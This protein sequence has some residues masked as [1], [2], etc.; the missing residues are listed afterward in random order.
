MSAAQESR[1]HLEIVH[2]LF[3]DVVGYSQLLVNEQREVVQQLNDI[4]RATAQYRQSSAAGKLICIATGDGMA[5]VFFQSP[6]E[7]VHCAME[8]ARALKSHPHVRLRMGVHSGPVDQLKDVNNQT[9]IAGI[10]INI[11]Q[12]VMDCGD[13]GHILIS[14]RVAD[15]LAQDRLWQP[16]LHELGEIEFKH[17]V[18]VGIVNLHSAEIGNP[19]VPAKVSRQRADS[20]LTASSYPL[21]SGTPQKSI[22]VLAFVNMS[23]DPENEFFSDGIAEEIINALSKVKALRVAA[24][25]SSFAFKGR[26]EDI[27]DV[28]RKLKVQTVL[29]GSV[30]KAGN[31]LRV[32][33]QLINVADGYH[34]WSERYDR[35][36]E[37]VFAIQDEIAENIVRALRVVLGED[38]KRAL[39]KPRAENV[40]A[41]EYYLR[42]RQVQYQFRRTGIQFARRMFER[43]MEIDPRHALALAGAA[44]CCSFLYMYWDASRANLEGADSYSRK[45][46]ELDPELAEAHASRGLVLSLSKR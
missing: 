12:R 5:L 19:Q 37:D 11:A 4:V 17:G 14:K 39:E 34:L 7:P 41:Y 25:T 10:G 24:R 6:E 40:K 46:L 22:A 1:L 38:E 29:E 26:N 36:L 8:I 32:T 13:S 20:K 45:A 28:G 43:A 15:D 35:Q 2:V 21:P 30:R 3:L 27:G 9:N 16:L 33:A 31:R 44:D 23:N 42:G 18:K